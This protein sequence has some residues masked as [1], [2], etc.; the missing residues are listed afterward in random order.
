MN[1]DEFRS[2]YPEYGYLND[3]QL[4][5]ALHNKYYS[6]LTYKQFATSFGVE[7]EIQEEGAVATFAD[8]YSKGVFRGF[9]NVASGLVGTAEWAI[10]GTQESLIEAKRRIQTTRD[11]FNPTHEGAAAWSGRVLG[12]AIPF[13]ATTMVGGYAGGAVA[14]VLGK[15]ARLG[16][17]LGSGGIAFAVEGDTAY[18]AAKNTGATESQAQTERVLVGSINAALEAWQID[19]L[20]GFHKVGKHSIKGFTRNIRN[21]AWNLI[22]GDINNFTG[23]IL[24]LAVAEGLQEAAQEGV[25]I[26]VPAALREEYPRLPD[27][28]PDY[29][30]ILT[31]IGEAGL[32]GAFAGTVL[33]GGGA[34]ISSTPSM[35][36]PTVKEA[37]T[38]AKAINESNLI[39]TEKA[40][41]LRDLDENV[42]YTKEMEAKGELFFHGTTDEGYIGILEKGV[43]PESI[44]PITKKRG[45]GFF[46]SRNVG[47]AIGFGKNIIQLKLKPNAKIAI[48]EN[49][50]GNFFVDWGAEGKLFNVMDVIKAS[51][52]QGFDAV[53][54]EAFHNLTQEPVSELAILNPNSVAEFAPLQKPFAPIELTKTEQFRNKMDDVVTDL[55]HLRPEEKEEISKERGK[56][57]AEFREIMKDVQDPR[58]RVAIAKQ[59]LKGRLK[60]QIDPLQDKFTSEEMETA[61][62]TITRATLLTEGDVLSAFEGMEKMLFDGTI[63]ALNEL[64]ALQKAN[65]LSKK[66]IKNLLK[67]RSKWQKTMSALKDLSFAPWSLLTSFDV[68]ASGRQGWK[69][70]FKE[71]ELWLR[72]VGR[73]YRML[74]SEKYFN[75]I[76]LKRKTHP[77]YNEAIKRGIEETTIDSVTRGEEMFASNMIQKVP[78]IRASARAFI[79]TI[80][81]MRFGWYFKGRQMS[82]GAGMTAKQQKDLAII[83][84]DLTGRGK[85]PKALKKLQD[86]GLIFFAPRLTAALIRTPA[87]LITKK[88]PGR[89]ML[90]GALVNFLGFTLAT[91]YLLDRDDKDKI[92][93]EWNPLSSDFLKVRHGKTRVDITGGYQPLLR[94]IAQVLAG[95]RKATETGRIYDVERK[96]IISRFLQSKLSP[97]A[98]LAVDLW[99]GET[100]RGDKLKL[101]AG[102]VGKQVYERAAP[103]F[104]QDVIEAA[105]YQGLTTASMI[106]PLAFHGIGVQTYPT[107][108]TQDVRNLKDR[109]ASQ[110]FGGQGWDEVGP[111]AQT[112]L[113]EYHPQIELMEREAQIDREDFDFIGKILEEADK[114]GRTIQKKLPKPVRSELDKYVMDVGNIT[115]NVGSGWY[116]N[117][118]RYAQYKKDI[119]LSLTK[120]LTLLINHPGYK[121][122]PPEVRREMIDEVISAAK[123]DVRMRLVTQANYEDLKTREQM[124]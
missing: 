113:R 116:L 82:E 24:K 95:K 32:G 63:P 60:K 105:H 13:M 97:H 104:I 48:P 80:N 123:K 75:Y 120:Y 59:A 21:K 10:P 17:L 41:L 76:E 26:G 1:L 89:K 124:K 54:L 51:K 33:G 70:F 3:V 115:R 88:G 31:Q 111:Q 108:L 107:T 71:P 46:I 94:A 66:A 52:K 96:E 91:L 58:Q 42:G 79:G 121:Q 27:G 118:K 100:F 4:S 93:V 16:Q 5:Q 109:L 6:Q 14:G 73:G 15:S 19:K 37:Q 61:Y 98:G 78:G 9:L 7:P 57:F 74:T 56:R 39:E 106:A 18:D 68:S 92:D 83:A 64:K 12:E 22:R 50:V 8:E 53:D 110:Y 47:K 55:E 49:L 119:S 40:V 102:D 28:S 45:L 90:A 86:I 44:D 25:S 99:R 2:Q 65:L 29:H 85:L 20:I 43:V 35:A 34:F 114:S 122:V 11:K 72:S 77:Y 84:N 112:E 62:D 81:E 23:E 30:F 69:V 103:L 36:A 38:T 117:D 67:H 101:T 87:D